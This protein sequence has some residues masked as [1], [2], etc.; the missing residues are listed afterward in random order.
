MIKIDTEEVINQNIDFLD[1][2]VPEAFSRAYPQREHYK[3]LTNIAFQLNYSLILDMGTCEGYSAVCLA[4]NLSNRVISYDIVKQ[5]HPILPNIE[6]RTMDC[7]HEKDSVLNSA[8]L[9]FVDLGHDGEDEKKL[10]DRLS[11]IGYK[12]LMLCDDIRHSQTTRHWFI[13]LPFK[14]YD[15]TEWGHWSGTGIVDFSKPL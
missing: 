2:V 7:N 9:I 12:G 4:R 6:Y 5:D 3:L 15:I 1:G 10:S 8:A 14:K 11:N 13:N